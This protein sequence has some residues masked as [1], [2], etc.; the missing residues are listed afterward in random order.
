MHIKTYAEDKP[1]I[2]TS[3]YDLGMQAEEGHRC[4]AGSNSIPIKGT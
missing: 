4:V 1:F 2:Q 3:F